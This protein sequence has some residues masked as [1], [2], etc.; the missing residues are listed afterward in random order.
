ML[1]PA[2]TR[3]V[4]GEVSVFEQLVLAGEEKELTELPY[5]LH[6]F[7]VGCLIEHVRDANV[8]HQTLALGF[9]DARE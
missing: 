5:H 6:N 9:L 1:L 2:Q 4:S 8:V 3:Y 7:L